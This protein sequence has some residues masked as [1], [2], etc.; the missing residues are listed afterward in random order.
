MTTGYRSSGPAPK[1]E[2]ERVRRHE[3][4][5]ATTRVNVVELIQND[6]EI[7]VPNV[8]WHPIASMVFESLTGSAQ[9]VYFEPSDWAA[10]YLLCESISRD[11]RPQVIAYDEIEHKVVKATK[12]IRGSNLTAYI[13]MMTNLLMTE[14]DRR[15]AGIEIERAVQ[16]ADLERESEAGDNVVDFQTARERSVGN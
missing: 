2:D 13:K 9:C 3:P 16:L 11:L 8:E 10:A 15:R 5:V 7:P 12:P 1:R 6:V 14:V 4:A